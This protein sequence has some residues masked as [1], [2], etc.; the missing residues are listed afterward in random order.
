LPGVFTKEIV[1]VGHD[2][3]QIK[4]TKQPLPERTVGLGMEF[5]KDGI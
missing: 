2:G 1:Y 3:M 4:Q 5:Q